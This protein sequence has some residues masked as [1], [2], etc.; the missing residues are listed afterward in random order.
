MDFDNR[1]LK[2]KVMTRVSN[3]VPGKPST[4]IKTPSAKR[5]T[6]EKTHMK[7][8]RARPSRLGVRLGEQGQQ[9]PGNVDRA[10]CHSQTHVSK[11]QES[12]ETN[13]LL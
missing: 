9:N 4:Q 11:L 3:R 8:G 2:A 12:S 13:I 5:G 1:S 6:V 10:Q 7:G